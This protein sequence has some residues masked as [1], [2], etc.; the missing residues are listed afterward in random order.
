V[1]K[2]TM[3]MKIRRPVSIQPAKLIP[4]KPVNEGKI[5]DSNAHRCLDIIPDDLQLEGVLHGIT[6]WRDRPRFL[7]G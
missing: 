2:K 4:A 5:L 1:G 6:G 3:I 7:S